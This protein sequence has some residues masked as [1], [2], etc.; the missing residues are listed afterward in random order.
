[1]SAPD[2]GYLHALV[3]G[4][5]AAL[6]AAGTF[7]ANYFSKRID[8]VAENSVSQKSFDARGEAYDRRLLEINESFRDMK[9]VQSELFAKI[10]DL[11]DN[12]ELRFQKIEDKATDRHVEL[13][14]AIHA[15]GK[16]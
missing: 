15:T 4:L 1:M 11:S 7:V 14:N 3:A 8:T 5:G 12:T 2:D 10:S 6:L 9:A 13:L 16:A